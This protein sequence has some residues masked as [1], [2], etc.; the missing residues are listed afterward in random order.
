MAKSG[1]SPPLPIAKGT[2]LFPHDNDDL[3]W[4]KVDEVESIPPALQRLYTDFCVREDDTYGCPKN[5]SD[6][7]A[8]WYLN[9]SAAPNVKCDDECNFIALCDIREGEELT[10][11]YRTFSENE[12]GCF[13]LENESHADADVGKGQASDRS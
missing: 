5:F 10:V 2:S 9:H 11:D 7:D 6:L 12:D 1:R 8:S 4:V 13:A 3:R